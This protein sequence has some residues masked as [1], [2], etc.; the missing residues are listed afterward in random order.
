MD[1]KFSPSSPL[2]LPSIDIREVA[3]LI[4]NAQKPDG[5][6][7]WSEGQKTDPW[8]HVESAMGLS[9]GG[10]L[11]ESQRAFEWMAGQQLDDGSWYT[12]YRQGVAEDQTRD[13][14]LS[15]YLAVG[16]FHYY[17][18]TEDKAFLVQMW[19]TLSK[20]IE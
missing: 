15:C 17:L 8:D 20:A 11:A 19:P 1:L 12:A 2:T 10:Y 3:S 16:L 18:I 4:A 6:I 13:A 7:P 9:V 14:N 5:E